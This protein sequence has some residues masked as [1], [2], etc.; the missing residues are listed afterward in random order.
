VVYNSLRGNGGFGVS[1]PQQTG[2]G[3]NTLDANGSAGIPAGVA[4][5][6]N[7]ISGVASCPQ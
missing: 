1:A 4:L 3:G 2:I 7:A 6:C 5:T